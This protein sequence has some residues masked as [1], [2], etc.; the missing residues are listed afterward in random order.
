MAGNLDLKEL[1]SLV[2]RDEIDTVLTVFPDG[3]GRLMGKRVV[4]RHFLEHVAERRRPR[5]HLPLHRRHG[6]GAAARLQARL[7][8]ARLRGHEGG[9][10]PRRRSAGSPGCRRRRSSSA[11]STRRRASRSRRRR[12]GSSSARSS[13]RRS[14]GYRVM[15]GVRARALPLQGVVRGGAREAL[16]RADAGVAST[17]RTT[18][19]SRRPRRSGWSAPSATAWRRPRCRSSSP[20]ASGG[21]GRRR[22]TSATPRRSR[23]PTATRSTSTARRRSRTP[24]AARSRSWRS[25]TWAR[26]ARRSTCTRPC[27]TGRARRACSPR[28]A[29]RFGS[30]ALRALAGRAD[31][32]GAR[33][34]VLLRALRQLVQALP[35]GLV[36]ADADRGRAGT[37]A[38]AAS[39]SAARARRSASRTGFPGAD[40]N[41][42]LAFAATIA[43]GLHGIQKK[44]AAPKV[45][46]GNAYEDPK[47]PQ[48]PK[49]LREAVAE[50]ERSRV[51]REAF[52]DE[53]VEHYLHTARLEQQAFDQAVTD[54]E[55]MRG[56]ERI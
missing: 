29:Q 23:W 19:S 50:L 2:R 8:G 37:T 43:A 20:R 38:P 40:A 26:P 56:F 53:V 22:S 31:G 35:G 16:P 49:T 47:L 6:D 41:P 18:T 33:A 36:R 25:T 7:V 51:A 55:L 4:G 34:R 39:G 1:E 15:I 17:S 45:Y 52:G 10:G 44:L 24:R 54:W 32:D 46:E 30:A 28:R 21:A 12:G 13:A 3:Q 9:P 14:S 5:L 11:T 27:G 48:V 42:Y